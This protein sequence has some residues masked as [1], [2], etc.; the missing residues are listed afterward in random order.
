MEIKPQPRPQDPPRTRH[1]RLHALLFR[2]AALGTAIL[3]ADPK[4]PPFRG[5]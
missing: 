4:L 5:E 3:L 2:G 1:T